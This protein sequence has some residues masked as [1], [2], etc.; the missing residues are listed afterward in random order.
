MKPI[1]S[2]AAI[3]LVAAIGLANQVMACNSPYTITNSGDNTANPATLSGAIA[4]IN[5]NCAGQ[6]AAITISDSIAGSTIVMGESNLDISTDALVTITGPT[7]NPVTT[8]SS[9]NGEAHFRVYGSSKLTIKNLIMDGANHGASAINLFEGGASSLVNVETTVFKNFASRAITVDAAH[10]AISDSQFINNS[11]SSASAN[12]GAIY[13]GTGSFLTVSNTTFDNNSSAG[14]GGAISSHGDVQITNSKFENNSTDKAGGAL[15]LFHPAN[16][17]TVEVDIT[18]TVFEGNSSPNEGSFGAGALYISPSESGLLD[19]TLDR[20][21]INNNSAYDGPGA[22]YMADTSSN[23]G[24]LKIIN[25]TIS[26]NSGKF[27]GGIT[28]SGGYSDGTSISHSTII[29]NVN[30]RSTGG[31]A[32]YGNG[33]TS[34]SDLAINHTIISGNTGGYAQVCNYNEANF[35]FAYVNSFVSNDDSSSSSCLSNKKDN[36][37]LVGNADN[38]LDPMLEALADNG[39]STKTHYPKFGSPV[40]DAGDKNI[41][42][43]PTTDQRG[44]DR[45]MRNG[46]DIG[47][48][49]YGNQAPELTNISFEDPGLSQG[50][51]INYDASVLFSD[52]EGD[53]L[54]ITATGLPNGASMTTTGILE[55]TIDDSGEFAITV[56]AED[57]YGAYR[58]ATISLTIKATNSSGGGA[59]P[60]NPIWLS[61]L[62]LLGLRRKHS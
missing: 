46:I 20:T 21:L 30:T 45:V 16:T 48:V 52:P 49:E 25:S 1:H 31:S 51:D 9:A 3:P 4:D 13:A 62:A 22:I 23:K 24:L 15:S 6:E 5:T 14:N 36:A 61:L 28:L 59:L 32:I 12:G 55:G 57:T 38:T 47:S 27:S 44:N 56:R 19:V 17:T 18:D 39:G 7:V 10:V 54:I 2:F 42:N 8:Q 29:N 50:E 33:L 60:A 40:I 35:D 43:A 26:N 58:E 53:S 11:T 37:S 34:A 41:Q